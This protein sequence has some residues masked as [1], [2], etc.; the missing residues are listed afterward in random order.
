MNKNEIKSYLSSLVHPVFAIGISLLV[1]AIVILMSGENP[2][3]IYGVMLKGAFGNKYYILSTLTRATPIIICGLGAALAWSSSYMGIGGEGQMIW[4]GFMTAIVT[5]YMPGP[6]FIK[7]IVAII[8]CV[9]SGGL[10]SLFSAWLFDKLEMSLAITTLMLNY[11]AQFVTYHYVSNIFLD[12]ESTR[13]MLGQTHL[14]PEGIRLAPI[15]EGYSL[16]IGFI[17]AV[18]LVGVMWFVMNKTK[19]GYESKMTGFNRNFCDYGGIHSK[20]IMYL[21]LFISGVIFALAGATEVLGL[22]HRYI[23]GMFVTTSY[24]WVGL[25]AALISNYNPIGV[26][27]TSIIL[28]AIQTGGT[29]IDRATSIPVEVSSIIQGCITLFISAKIIIN[30]RRNRKKS[31]DTK[32]TTVEEA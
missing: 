23:H 3:E 2:F 10:Y 29:A 15:F 9:L 13:G 26:L 14:I 7:F 1:G 6:I 8:V 30:F 12:R 31:K 22:Q 28:A 21:V 4:G 27:I 32:Q 17:F 25:N 24:A 18:I 5:I 20:K 11:V 19:F 16:H